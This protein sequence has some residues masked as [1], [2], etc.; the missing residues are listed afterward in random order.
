MR[1]PSFIRPGLVRPAIVRPALALAAVAALFVLP[2]VRDA[3][4][5]LAEERV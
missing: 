2:G 5:E 4:R 3:M 1:A